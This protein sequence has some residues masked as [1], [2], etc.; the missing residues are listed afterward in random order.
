MKEFKTFVL[1]EYEK[2]EEYLRN[3]HSEGYEFVNVSMPGFYTFKK[4]EPKDVVYRLDYN[5]DAS[6]DKQAYILMFEDAG[7]EYLQDMN[8]Y[9]YFRKEADLTNE[10]ENEIF[11]DNESKLEMMRKIVFTK[12]LPLLT[13]ALVCVFPNIF[14]FMSMDF[15]TEPFGFVV[16]IILFLLVLLYLYIFVRLAVGYYKVKKKY[17]K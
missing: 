12:M 8:G 16:F 2:E 15:T 17:K 3:R 9:S 6:K 14:N 5:P 11:Y 10:L 13:I 7:W 4:C 1:T